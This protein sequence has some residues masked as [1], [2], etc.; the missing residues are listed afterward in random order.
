MSSKLLVLNGTKR[1]HGEGFDATILGLI[2][3]KHIQEAI[4]RN[5][6]CAERPDN[7]AIL[8]DANESLPKGAHLYSEYA[9]TKES[10]GAVPLRHIQGLAE[11][12]KMTA[13]ALE[14]F[15]VKALISRMS[16]KGGSVA[17]YASVE[18]RIGER[19]AEVLEAARG[20]ESI[21]VVSTQHNQA[22]AK[23]TEEPSGP[24]QPFYQKAM[25]IVLAREEGQSMRARQR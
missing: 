7:E 1:L 6:N 20:L 3:Q 15:G 17:D 2:E 13:G 5:A 16:G 10:L 9:S 19:Y 14:S 8:R 24:L 21:G 18:Q 25:A 11:R 4:A 22:L 23:L 12:V